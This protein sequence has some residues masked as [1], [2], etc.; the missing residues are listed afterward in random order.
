MDIKVQGKFPRLNELLT[1][2]PVL[3]IV[4]PNE[5]FVV[6]TDACKEGIGG[7]LTQN[8]HVICYESRNLKENEKNY[9]TN[10]LELV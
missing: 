5:D 4:V 9:A 2:G 8:G 6:C 3:K 7:I 1:N 10:D